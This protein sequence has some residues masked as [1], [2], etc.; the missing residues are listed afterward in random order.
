MIETI[1]S[2]LRN[3]RHEIYSVTSEATVQDVVSIMAEKGVAA[4]LVLAQGK[5]AEIVSAKDYGTRSYFKD[6]RQETPQFTRS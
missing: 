4:V 5:L 2:I 6:F 3:K 1:A